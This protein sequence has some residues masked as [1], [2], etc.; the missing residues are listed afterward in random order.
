MGYDVVRSVYKSKADLVFEDGKQA[1]GNEPDYL[2]GD[3]EGG[4]G[5]REH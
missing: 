3:G 2:L 4:S 5:Q 1:S